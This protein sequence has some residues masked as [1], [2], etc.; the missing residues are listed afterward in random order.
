M[1]GGVGDRRPRRAGETKITEVAVVA[2]RREICPPCGGC[3]QRLSEFADAHTLV[4]LGRP[5]GDITTMTLGDLLPLS[6]GRS[7]LDA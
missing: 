3:R 4:H 1:R 2:E 7:D 5:G 6:F